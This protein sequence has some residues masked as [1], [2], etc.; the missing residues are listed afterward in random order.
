MNRVFVQEFFEIHSFPVQ[1]IHGILVHSTEY[2][3]HILLIGLDIKPIAIYRKSLTIRKL[4]MSFVNVFPY[5]IEL[6]NAY[7]IL[8]LN[9]K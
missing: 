5:M 8:L 4:H 6:R 9:W 7:D 1:I 2:I 3:L